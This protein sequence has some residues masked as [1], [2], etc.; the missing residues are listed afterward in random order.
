MA[1][2]YQDE[3]TRPWNDVV[4]E[5][6]QQVQAVINDQ[7]AFTTSDHAAFVCRCEQHA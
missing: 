7:A 6:R 5:V 3:I 2:H 4:Q 1:D